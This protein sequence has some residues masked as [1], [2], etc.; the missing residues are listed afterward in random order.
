MG[1]RKTITDQKVADYFGMPL[2]TYTRYKVAPPGSWRKK[3]YYLMMEELVRVEAVK[4][5]KD[6]EELE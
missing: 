3:I 2:R 6:Y 1:K 5:F 4:A